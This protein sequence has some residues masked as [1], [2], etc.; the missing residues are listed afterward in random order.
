MVYTR[1]REAAAFCLIFLLT[2]YIR[3]CCFTFSWSVTALVSNRPQYCYR[4]VS[5]QPRALQST[6][7]ASDVWKAAAGDL[8]AVKLQLSGLF[9]EL[10]DKMEEEMVKLSKIKIKNDKQSNIERIIEMSSARAITFMGN[11]I[12]LILFRWCCIFEWKPQWELSPCP[13]PC[14]CHVLCSRYGLN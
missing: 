6:H 14:F 12:M 9:A 11:K 2:E 7:S 4:A 13:W 10:R 8:H 5:I 1:W 3:R